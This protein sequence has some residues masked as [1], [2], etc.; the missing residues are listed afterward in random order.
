MKK[1]KNYK[2]SIN[3]MAFSRL[4]RIIIFSFF[5]F[6]FGLTGTLVLFSILKKSPSANENL[7]EFI[8]GEDYSKGSGGFETS[9]IPQ[10]R[11]KKSDTSE[12]LNKKNTQSEKKDLQNSNMAKK[13]SQKEFT[14]VDELALID[15][16][17]EEEA[18]FGNTD[19][20]NLDAAAEVLSQDLWTSE[21]PELTYSTYCVQKCDMIGIIAEKYNITQ[22]TI[23]SV[24]NIQRSRLIQVGQYL[25]IPTMPGILY[26][27]KKNGETIEQIAEKNGISAVKCAKVNSLKKDSQLAAGFTIFLPDAQL[28]WVTRQEINGDLFIRPLHARY[29][30]SSPFGWRN[31]P[32]T[33][34]RSYHSGID[35]AV[36]MNTPVY[37]ALGGKVTSTG[38]NNVYGNYIILTHHSGYKT[39]YAHLSKILV[40]KGSYADTNKMIGR[41]G[42]TG[43]STGPHL[44]FTVYKFGKAVNPENLWK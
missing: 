14:D 33:G 18:G 28:D 22:D 38:F 35:M 21:E 30:T 29:W 20:D 8:N 44:H 19:A 36:A 13:S 3:R 42:N 43:M 15:S 23:I 32:F 4:S 34:K 1:F 27:V 41:V 31:S 26:T 9:S 39:L 17:F 16:L 12:N 7:T 25:K 37:A 5:A 11:S 6:S 2:D 24:N 40:T 10:F